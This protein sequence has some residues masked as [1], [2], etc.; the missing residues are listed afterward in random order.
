VIDRD[1]LISYIKFMKRGR[2]PKPKAERRKKPL[3]VMLND[4]ERLIIDT[5]AKSKSLDSS[6]WARQA[7]LAAAAK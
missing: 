2:P 6:A 3:R 1:I 5:A 7:L 4:A